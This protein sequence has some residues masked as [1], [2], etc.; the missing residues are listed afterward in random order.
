MRGNYNATIRACFGGYMVQAVINT[1][2]PLLFLTLRREYGLS[3]EEISLLI[4][5]NF[6]VQLTVDLLAARFVDRI[7]YRFSVVAAHLFSAAG[8]V[9][10]TVLPQWMPPLAGLL[11]AVAVYAVGGG[12]IEVLISPIVEACPTRHKES[13]MS[14]LHSFYCWGCVATILLSTLFFSLLGTGPWRVLAC[15]WALLPLVNGAIF[16]QVPLVSLTPEDGSGMSLRQ[17]ARQPAFWVLLLLMACAGASEHGVSQWAS[18]LAE[19]ALGVSK[20]VGDLAGPLSFAL[21]MGLSRV[22]Y[23]KYGEKISLRPYMTLCAALCVAGY[24]LTALSPWP[25]LSLAG[26]GLCGLAV[27]CMW[28]GTFSLAAGRFRAG[29]TALFALLA[30]AGDLG[31]S[32]G[33]T[34]VGVASSA[35][36]GSLQRGIL[37]GAVSPLLL[38]AGLLLLGHLEKK[39]P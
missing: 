12:L 29:G 31:C 35:L 28:P 6:L 9:L 20:T 30:L 11:I 3:L 13:V 19:S 16:T 36:G 7:G 34:A 25:A 23:A 37:L 39:N 26:C 33:P 8:L 15:L 32:A 22:F 27:G 21:L 17:L 5:V 24:L 14:L 4:T 38:M 10:L 2:V 1:F 18:A